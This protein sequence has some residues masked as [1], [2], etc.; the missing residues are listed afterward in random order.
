MLGS[1]KKY[2]VISVVVYM[3]LCNTL[4][5][6]EIGFYE[7]PFTVLN[8]QG[9]AT[10]G[11]EHDG[12]DTV[13]N[14]PFL[15]QSSNLE[16]LLSKKDSTFLIDGTFD[17]GYATGFWKFRFGVF[18]AKPE[19]SVVD[20]QY[21]IAASGTQE[22]AQGLMLQ[23]KPEGSWNYTVRGIKDAEI[24]NT[25]FKS[26]ITFDNGIPQQNFRVEND[27][28]VLVGRLLRNGLAQDEWVLYATNQLDPIERWLFQNGLLEKIVLRVDGKEQ[29][30]SIFDANVKE[31]K[32]V[33]LDR[34]FLRVL[35]V[36][37]GGIGNVSSNHVAQLLSQNENY[38]ENLNAILGQLGTADLSP[39]FGVRLP[40]YP[41]DSITKNYVSSVV[42]DVANATLVSDA[43]MDNTLLN[44]LKLSDTEAS[45]LYAGLVRITEEQLPPLQ[46]LVS[47]EDSDILEFL[48]DMDIL[49]N[50]WPNGIDE[51][52]WADMETIATST[53]FKYE[54]TLALDFQENAMVSI[55]KL[56]Q[57]IA[58]HT[59]FIEKELKAKLSKQE[60]EQERIALDEK[61]LSQ[62]KK[63][64]QLIDSLGNSLPSE[65]QKTLAY[66]QTKTVN[67]LSKPTSTDDLERARQLVV[68]HENMY[69][70]AQT[71][72]AQPARTETLT[73]LYTDRIWNPFMA[74]L[75]DEAVKK[76]ITTAYQ[77]VLIPYF[78]EQINTN[79]NC[80]NAEEISL[81]LD[82]LYNRMLELP[83]EE[84]KK[85]ERKLRK[86]TDALK[87][88]ELLRLRPDVNN[89]GE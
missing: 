81:L 51:P 73:K 45:K 33:S 24:V 63:L 85:L 30:I 17:K 42:R 12:K 68:C 31:T 15:M 50:L 76:R 37:L 38:Y 78:L 66:I 80:D 60:L 26:S 2:L 18:E 23:G 59:A 27:S 32:K 71:V 56:A 43:Y 14:G 20:Y 89:S 6:Q 7:G 29:S 22:E 35:E 84:T 55:A 9:K 39:N 28:T 47:Y 25:R 58:A 40:F 34:R 69:Q 21:R 19:S 4:V 36:K 13:L 83:D 41:M 54:E 82:A 48:T 1:S 52:V 57:Y 67:N 49:D 46:K 86:E 75:M 5:A 65:Y 61:L 62:N 87:I 79:L 3:I 72:S 11:Y 10:Y 64:T 53:G 88:Q 44:I 8:Y 16:A 77:Q 70:L 74:T